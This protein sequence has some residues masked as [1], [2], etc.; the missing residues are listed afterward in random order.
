[1][2]YWFFG[3]VAFLALPPLL[4]AASAFMQDQPGPPKSAELTLAGARSAIGKTYVRWGRARVSIDKKELESI[5]APEFYVSLYGEKLSRKKF[6]N[7]ISTEFRGRRLTRFDVDILTVRKTDW[8]WTAVIAEKIEQT[9]S[10]SGGEP[11]KRC[12]YWVTRDGFSHEGEKL[13][14][15]FSEVIGHESWVPGETPPI[16]DW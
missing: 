5:L 11:K 8:G 10:G 9:I 16:E 3:L 4:V 6:L 14:I 7:E 13:L 1:M 2:C 12:S 15:T